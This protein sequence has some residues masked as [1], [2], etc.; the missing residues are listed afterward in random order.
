MIVNLL[1]ALFTSTFLIFDQFTMYGGLTLGIFFLLILVFI[2]LLQEGKGFEIKS[3]KYFLCFMFVIY[4][5]MLVSGLRNESLIHGTGAYYIRGVILVLGVL[6]IAQRLNLNRSLRVFNL[7]GLLCAT[8]VLCQA[9]YILISKN[10]VSPVNILPI[11]LEQQRLWANSFRASG[12]FSEPQ[13]YATY[14]IPLIIV[15]VIFNKWKIAMYFSISVLASGS[16]Y[17]FA[18]I[19]ILLG[20]VF[21]YRGFY[22]SR[23]L[24]YML[25]LFLILV[26]GL[27]SSGIFDEGIKKLFSTNLMADIRVGKGL[28]IFYEMNAVEK[29]FGLDV[30][31]SDYVRENIVQFPTLLPYLLEESH[32]LNYIS[33]FWGI[34][35]H[36]GLIS[37]IPFILFMCHTYFNGD[38]YKKAMVIFIIAHSLSATMMLNGYF[39]YLFILLLAP[40]IVDETNENIK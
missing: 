24:I 4:F 6:I 7:F 25:P 39:V 37:L 33:G 19:L 8:V 16:T 18:I 28:L 17:G 11:P 20:W 32:L 29:L 2:I 34:V 26:L 3:N 27:L 10:P 9:L 1:T 12:V 13:L 31:V 35:I 36:Y 30:S 21:F 5:S 23:R 15:N 22:K 40:S 14:M 38:F